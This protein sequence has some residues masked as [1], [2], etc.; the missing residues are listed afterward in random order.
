M[1]FQV[2]AIYLFVIA[3]SMCSFYDALASNTCTNVL[4]LPVTMF[5]SAS[6]IPSL[7]VA[8]L[9]EPVDSPLAPIDVEARMPKYIGDSPFAPLDAEARSIPEPRLEADDVVEARTPEVSSS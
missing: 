3:F 1:Q 5:V 8:R 4:L 7:V 6:P 9:P 2:S